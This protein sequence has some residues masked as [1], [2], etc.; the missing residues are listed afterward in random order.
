[1][2]RR[3]ARYWLSGFGAGYMP[4]APASWGSLVGVFLASWMSPLSEGIRLSIWAGYLG[5]SILCSRWGIFVADGADPPWVVADEIFAV[6][7]VGLFY[8]LDSMQALAGTFIFFRFWDVAKIYPMDIAERWPAPWGI[9]G[10]D[11]V[12]AAYTLAC[13]VLLGF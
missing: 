10:D 2:K 1:M 11:V 3:F 12:A 7:T 9:F 6:L 5:I 8:P 13:L 4:I